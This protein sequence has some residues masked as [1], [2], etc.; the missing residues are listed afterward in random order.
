MSIL[1]LLS[2]CIAHAEQYERFGDWEVHYAVL[3][4]TFLRPQVAAA[5]EIVR[6]RDRSLINVSVLDGTASPARVAVTGSATN[7]LGQ[8]IQLRFREVLDGPAVYYLAQIEH[9]DE[10]VMRFR[11]VVNTDDAREMV[12]QFQ[13]KLYWEDRRAGSDRQ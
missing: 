5:Y 9:S 13:Q 10:E 7:L 11:I 3:P 8:Q 12:V 2:T 6:A 4:T 1:L